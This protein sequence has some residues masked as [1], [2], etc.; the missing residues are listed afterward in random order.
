MNAVSVWRTTKELQKHLGKKGKVVVWTKIFVS[1]EG[2][3]EQAPY[4]VAIVEFS[5][6]ERMTLQVV[7]CEDLQVGQEVRLVV[8]RIGKAGKEDVI[9]YG[10]KARPLV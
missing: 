8:R 5:P 4:N 1:P 2:F 3:E 7:D 9:A 10:L 6:G